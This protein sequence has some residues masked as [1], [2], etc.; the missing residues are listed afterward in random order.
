MTLSDDAADPAGTPASFD[1]EGVPTQRVALLEAGVCR[2]VVHDAR[3]A[4]RGPA[5]SPPA[6]GCRR[7]TRGDPSR[8]T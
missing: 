3:T 4:P 6:T 1:F 7:P 8:C 2:D 5:A